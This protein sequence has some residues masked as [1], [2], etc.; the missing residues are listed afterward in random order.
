MQK[1]LFKRTLRDLRAN[2]FRYMALF[3]LII[4]CM[5][6]VVGTIGSAVSV[7]E[8]VN[9]RADANHLEDGQFGVLVPL[10]R[11]TLQDFKY[12]QITLEECFYLDFLMEDTSTLRVMKNRESINLVN[13]EE[14]SPAYSPGEIVV[15]RI[16]AAAHNLSIGDNI[17]IAGTDYTISG[18]GTSPDYEYC[19]QNMSDMNSDGNVFGTAFVSPEAYN[20]LL[21]GGKA[22][23]A[24]E[25]RY[26]YLL[27]D[28]MTH[29]NLKD[30]LMDIPINPAE[31]KDSFFREMTG[32]KTK[33]QNV[34]TDFVKAEDNP[35]IKAANRD[36]E[37]NIK[38]GLA[39]GIIVLILIT[40]V[41]SVFIIHTIDQESPVIGALYASGLKRKQ[42]LW[43][44]TMLPVL[45]CFLGG[46]AGTALGCSRLGMSMMTGETYT[47]YSTPSI[48][49]H[50]SCLLLI[51]GI[52]LPPLTA[53]LVTRILIQKRLKRSA[54]SLLRKEIPG[55]KRNG[56]RLR[57]LSFLSMFQIRQFMREKRSC[58]AILAGMFVSL[59]IL[60]LGLNCYSLCLNIKQQNTADTRFSYMYQYKY[61]AETVP[62]GGFPAFVKGLKKDVFGY[63][64]EVR[65]IGLTD[66]NP[67]FPD[68]SQTRKD[69]ICISSSVAA[70]YRLSAG[71]ELILKDEVSEI[72]YRFTITEI[73]PY[74][75]GLC[76]FMDI[77]SM[78][79]LFN[80][81]DGYYNAV[82]SNTPLGIDPGCLYAVSTKADIEKS[83]DIFMEIMKPLIIM[84]TSVSILVFL[85]VLYQMTKVMIDRSSYNISLMKI[86][87]YRNKEIRKL[88]LDGSVYL[89]AFGSL[90][91]LP[92]GKILIDFIY[93]SFI[94][95]IACGGDLS[96][97]PILYS[98]VYVGILLCYFL[99]R[100]LLLAKLKELTPAQVLKDKE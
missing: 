29:S 44:Y 97:P 96:W 56:I 39:A 75:T 51:Y 55:E 95:N 67:F 53:L 49:T 87:G 58:L 18:I 84:L 85:I 37:I 78:R 10:D 89:I 33:D 8:T 17:K 68:F 99:V 15:E 74:S 94:I 76:C 90:L 25:Y 50:I 72:L 12:A 42:L 70:K 71:D 88:Y 100:T 16:F 30:Y 11:K 81:D 32:R 20:E 59:L 7:I 26:S 64:L 91:M 23:H 13:L 62:E 4:L 80:Q 57:R 3:L 73:V 31:L 48:E 35:R 54:L 47:Y 60:I 2:F 34:L 63:P 46:A 82:Y 24:E 28:H 19:L 79:A 93:P 22:L 52:L 38:V 65:I 6:I 92:A 27:G 45:L 9:K 36:V 1:L 69:E 83:S 41:I 77:D 40:Y 14:G 21:A 98:I 61:P 66:D 5:F 86:F 43:H